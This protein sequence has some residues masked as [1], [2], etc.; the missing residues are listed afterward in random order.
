MACGSIT[1]TNHPPSAFQKRKRW[2]VVA[3]PTPLRTVFQDSKTQKAETRLATYGALFKARL[4]GGAGARPPFRKKVFRNKTI[5]AAQPPALARQGEEN[6][7][8]AGRVAAT[9]PDPSRIKTM[10]QRQRAT[11]SSPF[12]CVPPVAHCPGQRPRWTRS[13]GLAHPPVS[14]TGCG[15]T[16]G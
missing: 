12:R 5:G 8:S 16:L 14:A 11:T 13:A 9:G 6:V 15:H 10:G 3:S 7:L 2:R 4:Q 1:A